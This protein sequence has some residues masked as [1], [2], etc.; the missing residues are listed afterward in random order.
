L[1]FRTLV[2]GA[3]GGAE[4]PQLCLEPSSLSI[5]AQADKRLQTELFCVGVVSQIFGGT[6]FKNC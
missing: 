3:E 6:K 4:V 5:V 2:R 1:L